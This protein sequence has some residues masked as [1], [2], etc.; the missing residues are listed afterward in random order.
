MRLRNDNLR[1]AHLILPREYSPGAASLMLLIAGPADIEPLQRVLDLLRPIESLAGVDIP[2]QRKLDTLDP[3]INPSRIVRVEAREFW[4]LESPELKSVLG[5]AL[6]RLLAGHIEIF[7]NAG[8]AVGG[9]AEGIQFLDREED[10]ENIGSLL[11]NHNSVVIRAPRRSG[12]TSVLRKLQETLRDQYGIHYLDLQRD[13]RMDTAAARL[14]SMVKDTAFRPAISEV[15]SKGWEAAFIDALDRMAD[16]TGK[17]PLLML[18]ELVF[19]LEVAIRERE[20]D[21]VRN[22]LSGLQRVVEK[23]GAR[24]LF[25]GSLDLMEFIQEHLHNDEIPDV[26]KTAVTYTLPPLAE[27][28]LSVQLRRLLL[29]TGLV[30]EDRDVE[31]FSENVD[32]ALPYPGQLFLDS[33]SHELRRATHIGPKELH[34]SLE[35]FLRETDSFRDFENHLERAPSPRKPDVMAALTRLVEKP[36]RS[37]APLTQI[38]NA[39][40]N[41]RDFLWMTEVFPVDSV[42]DR[43]RCSSRLWWRWWRG[44]VGLEA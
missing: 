39:V 33:L 1:T 23:T 5:P 9:V 43:V 10:L 15:E 41:D 32:I 12:K 13:R 11:S 42:E 30:L 40:P 31:W 25:A 16:T 19:L 17:E 27:S 34:E 26:L 4:G 3:K 7:P 24:I 14:L 37:G 29:G 18:D 20:P 22:S 6:D 38:R 35:T 28:C 2:D 8:G 36:F 21:I 44:Q